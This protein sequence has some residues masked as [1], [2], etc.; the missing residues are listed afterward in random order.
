MEEKTKEIENGRNVASFCT[1]YTVEEG[2]R[3]IDEYAFQGKFCLRK[4]EVPRTLRTVRERAF[5]SCAITEVSFKEGV[6]EILGG[7]FQNCRSLEKV[8]L[9]K[10]IRKIDYNAF[11]ATRLKTLE[12]HEGIEEIGEQIFVDTPTIESVT[13]PLHH[14]PRLDRL[15]FSGRYD[16]PPIVE[17]LR[18]RT[19]YQTSPLCV[20]FPK[21][22]EDEDCK[23]IRF[24][25]AQQIKCI[26]SELRL[27]GHNFY[28]CFML[29]CV[30]MGLYNAYGAPVLARIFRYLFHGPFRPFPIRHTDKL[31]AWLR[32]HENAGEYELPQ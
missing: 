4:I 19:I 20:P 5:T 30:Q 23:I 11:R 18:L 31:R 10:G 24:I 14:I 1:E 9:V 22:T 32:E 17:T 13:L 12:I 15:A 7:G 26:R 25:Q 3:V 21:I 29:K 28:T 16:G 27:L 6:E 2:V 8:E